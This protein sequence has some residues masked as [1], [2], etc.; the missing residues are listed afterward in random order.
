M[1]A[2]VVVAFV[3]RRKFQDELQLIALL[4]DI[5]VETPST[6]PLTLKIFKAKD[7]GE[8]RNIYNNLKS[9]GAVNNGIVKSF[10]P[11]RAHNGAKIS[12]LF[13]DVLISSSMSLFVTCVRRCEY[14]L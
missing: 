6:P 10:F 9:V 12:G 3:A 14:T 5:N 2:D 13:V 8:Y 1:S 11:F 4:F 7:F